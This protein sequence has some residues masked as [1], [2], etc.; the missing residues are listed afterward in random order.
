M[1]VD[2]VWITCECAFSFIY[3]CSC[4]PD[5]I[6]KQTCSLSS[7]IVRQLFFPL[8]LHYAASIHEWGTCLDF[9]PPFRCAL[10]PQFCSLFPGLDTRL[11][12]FH[13][14]LAEEMIS[15]WERWGEERQANTSLLWTR[16]CA[17]FKPFWFQFTQ[18]AAKILFPLP[19]TTVQRVFIN[20]CGC[21]SETFKNW[22]WSIIEPGTFMWVHIC[23]C[24]FC[25]KLDS[26]WYYTLYSKDIANCTSFGYHNV[27]EERLYPSFC[28]IF[29]QYCISL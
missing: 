29:Y 5:C 10:L 15:D 22:Y 2:Y 14:S 8:N 25:Q 13:F 18:D 16:L 28:I 27:L 9:P 4:L 23:K 26:L 19:S 24:T 6:F 11:F 1:W 20:V 21:F 17:H 3:G 7:D 12:F